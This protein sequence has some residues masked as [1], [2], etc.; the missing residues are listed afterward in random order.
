[1]SD[2]QQALQIILD[3]KRKNEPFIS[4]RIKAAIDAMEVVPY[5]DHLNILRAIFHVATP[6]ESGEQDGT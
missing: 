1:M 3:T 6:E 5:Y 2:L 4:V